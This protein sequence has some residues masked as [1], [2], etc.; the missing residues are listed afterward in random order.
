MLKKLH[1]E[2]RVIDWHTSVR[3]FL[4]AGLLA[5]SSMIAY[6]A[7]SET[8][9]FFMG[10]FVALGILILFDAIIPYH[11]R[12]HLANVIVSFVLGIVVAVIMSPVPT[13][14]F[15]VLIVATLAVYFGPI[16]TFIH[17]HRGEKTIK[18]ADD[19]DDDRIVTDY[20]PAKK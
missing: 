3:C 12:L 13:L 2:E 6:F 1:K 15:L 17:D 8:T 20:N 16:K 7:H 5:T 19:D 18:A 10:I 14:Y 9:A 4:S 11:R